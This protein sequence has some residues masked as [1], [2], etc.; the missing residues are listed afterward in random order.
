MQRT[1]EHRLMLARLTLPK[2]R[3]AMA[4][5]FCMGCV[6]SSTMAQPVG[7]SDELF[8]FRPNTPERQIRGAILAE[9]LDRPQ[10]ALGYLTDLLDSQPSIEVLLQLR[11]SFGSGT[12]LRLSSIEELQPTSRELLNL[13][14][15]AS[16]QDVTS[17]AEVEGLINEL[18]QSKQQTLDASLKILSLESAAVVAL[19]NADSST[20]HGDLADRLLKKYVRRFQ[21]GLLDVLPTADDETQARVLGILAGGADSRIVAD[22]VRYRFSESA[23][24]ARAATAAIRKLSGT[25]QAL[26]SKQD[27]ADGLLATAMGLVKQAGTRFPNDR[28]RAAD[29][30]LQKVPADQ[31]VVYGAG[32]LS[33]AVALTDSAAQIA[34]DD[35]S[36]MAVK[37][38]AELSEQSWPAIWPT[39]IKL[40]EGAIET[41]DPTHA[42]V[43][44]LSVAAESENVAAILSLLRR[45]YAVKILEQ[46][47]LIKQQLLR[48]FDPRV[49]LLAAGCLKA[50]NIHDYRVSAVLAG[51]VAGNSK[52]DA[53]VIDTRRGEGL[54]V[55][56]VLAG[57]GYGTADSR[58]GQGGFDLAVNQLG[59]ELILVHSNVLRW[60]LSQTVG[61]LRADYR[62]KFVPIV[63]YGPERD[64]ERTKLTRSSYAGIWFVSEP[65]SDQVRDVNQLPGYSSSVSD[66]TV[67]LERFRLEGIPQAVLNKEERLQMISFARGLE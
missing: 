27:A 33:R 30:F 31:P 65:I 49:R 7:E 57:A 46:E 50:A 11:K 21:P 37:T 24:V 66:P 59:C 1:L 42:D 25:P 23:D 17:A 63:V 15:E 54:T 12:F 40:Q 13:I 2:I 38:V 45:D 55:A 43:L 9:K 64:R 32:F 61:N 19:L 51:A 22:L 60:S 36:V 29:R 56:A 35:V 48:H 58:T 34:P 18:G 5:A 3:R 53:T 8:L 67:V 4:I 47:P 62:T 6:A 14:N 39:E 20:P 16:R 28:Q 44:T 26:G 41:P 52:P 10:L